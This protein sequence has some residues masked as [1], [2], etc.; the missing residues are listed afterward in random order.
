MQI[1]MGYASETVTE[2]YCGAMNVAYQFCGS[3]NFIAK[4]PSDGKF[5]NCCHNGK[6]NLIRPVY[7]QELQKLFTNIS[8]YHKNF[9]NIRSYNS[10]FAFA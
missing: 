4:K 2:H 1:H 9:N 7:P 3:V 5:N 10:S 8:T 6:L